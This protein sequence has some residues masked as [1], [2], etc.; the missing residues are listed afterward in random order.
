MTMLVLK[1]LVSQRPG[2]V[3]ALK[4]PK[5]GRPKDGVGEAD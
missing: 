3:F 5:A 4:T 2:N 1:G